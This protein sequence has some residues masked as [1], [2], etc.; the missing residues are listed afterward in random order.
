M[1]TMRGTFIFSAVI[2]GGTALAIPLLTRSNTVTMARLFAIGIVA[3]SLV[4]LIGLAGQVS[5]ASGASPGIGAITMAHLGVGG[6]APR[7]PL[8][9]RV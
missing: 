2:V 5:L 6:N 9:V 8:G 4:P 1:P 7:H 3:L